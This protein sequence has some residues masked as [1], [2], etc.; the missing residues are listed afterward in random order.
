MPST[1]PKTYSPTPPRKLAFIG[2]G[3]MGYPMAGHLALAGH[4]VSVYN[5]NPAKSSAWCQ[6]FAATAGASS[7]PTPKLAAQGAD[8][9]LCCVGNDEDLRSVTLGVD[10]GDGNRSTDGAF[11]GRHKGAIFVDHT[12]ASASVAR[13]LHA[14]AKTLGLQFVDAPVSGGQAGAQNGLLTV[15][16]GDRSPP[17]CSWRRLPARLAR[18]QKGFPRAPTRTS[19]SRHRFRSSVS[20][21]SFLLFTQ[22]LTIHR[23]AN[24][25]QRKHV[26]L[27]Y[28][29]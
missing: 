9:V 29:R 15:M 6:E 3:V 24:T 4:R 2:L 12:T 11:A 8:M 1:H 25:V 23:I 5:R 19:P 18:T 26:Y 17:R 28:A 22:Q 14:H 13:E 21:C 16:C 27:E 10:L 7:A 20:W